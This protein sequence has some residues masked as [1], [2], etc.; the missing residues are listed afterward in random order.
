MIWATTS[1]IWSF[2]AYLTDAK[3]PDSALTE[4]LG[5]S[6]MRNV[7][8]QW[9][10]TLPDHSA[11]YNVKCGHPQGKGRW[12]SSDTDTC[13]Q[14]RGV[15]KRVFFRTSFMNDPLGGSASAHGV[16]L[17]WGSAPL[18]RLRTTVLRHSV[19]SLEV[20]SIN[21]RIIRWKHTVKL[22]SRYY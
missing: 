5:T 18:K 6:Q 19:N 8:N 10:I 22:T 15:G 3:P 9:H 17:P 1:N 13:G 11:V 14:G 21:F 16:R 20:E 4:T 7:E 2:G 12:V